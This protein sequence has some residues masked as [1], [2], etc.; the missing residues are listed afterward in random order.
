MR[1]VRATNIDTGEKV[2]GS[3]YEVAELFGV[4]YHAINS[5]MRLGHHVQRKWDIEYVGE[6]EEIPEHARRLGL[7]KVCSICGEAFPAHRPDRMYCS[8]KCGEEA[9]RV[10]QRKVYP[11]RRKAEAQRMRENTKKKKKQLTI[12]EISVLARE[13][14]M[15]YGM[16]VQMKGL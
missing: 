16:Y 12:G 10:R 7:V 8:P 3:I 11:Q 5:A 1:I 15:S 9:E 6:A 14:G 4:T 13:A 2:E